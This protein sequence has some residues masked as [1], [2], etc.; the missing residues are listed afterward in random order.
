MGTGAFLSAM[1]RGWGNKTL[2][3]RCALP[4]GV[5]SP[6]AETGDVSAWLGPLRKGLN[7][8]EGANFE[9]NR[10]AEPLRGLRFPWADDVEA[11]E[12]TERMEAWEGDVLKLPAE[13]LDN[14]P[15]ASRFSTA[16]VGDDSPSSE[17]CG[18]SSI[19]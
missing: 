7:S 19:R 4:I 9:R 18:L 11:S 17:G 13:T 3:D 10:E 12:R 16:G 8:H 15:T 1:A 14:E 6:D 2:L 5:D